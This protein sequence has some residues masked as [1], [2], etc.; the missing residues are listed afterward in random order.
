V[1]SSTCVHV[2]KSHQQQQYRPIVGRI[3]ERRPGQKRLKVDRT[4]LV[5]IYVCFF[6]FF[7]SSWLFLSGL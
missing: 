6:F 7:F 2:R 1:A 5:Y 3:S 4:C